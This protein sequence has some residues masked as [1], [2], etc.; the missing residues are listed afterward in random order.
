METFSCV[1][2]IRNKVTGEVY[3]GSSSQYPLRIKYHYTKLR[4]HKHKS[5]R[6]QE[7]WN[8]HGEG[9]FEH[10]HLERCQ[11]EDLGIKEEGWLKDLLV[12]G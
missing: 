8:L 4:N 2:A 7:S 3:I 5:W 9:C 6:L 12:K 1:Y 10:Y 11:E